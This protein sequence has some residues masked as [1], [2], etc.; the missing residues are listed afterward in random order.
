MAFAGHGGHTL[1]GTVVAPAASGGN[2]PAMLLVGGSDWRSRSQLLPEA[3]A[4]A[5]LGLVTL[6]Y[7][8]RSAA[9]YQTDYQILADDAHAGFQTL[10]RQP[11]VD[12]ERTGLWG[13]SEGA[14]IA[15]IVASRSPHVAYVVTVGAVGMAPAR[16]TAWFWSNLLHHRGV[17]GS[18]L[19]SFPHTFMRFAVGAGLFPEAN[20]DPIP[21]LERVRQPMLLL[22]SSDDFVHPPRESA[23]AMRRAL[24]RGTHSSCSPTPASRSGTLSRGGVPL[25]V[26]PRLLPRRA[27]RRD[28]WAAPRWPLRSARRP[29]SC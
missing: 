19:R 25:P 10:R 14:W 23:E 21:A 27:G 26:P 3:E 13:R 4:F 7:D 18:L 28:G 22:W 9:Q 2:R 8:K 17:S 6:V 20:Y 16:Q 11:R 24:D 15:P 29:A 1:H 5:R 12:P